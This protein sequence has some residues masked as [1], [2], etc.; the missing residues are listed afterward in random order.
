MTN[1]A[2]NHL[3]FFRISVTYEM[4]T[5]KQ[6]EICISNDNQTIGEE[7]FYMKRKG[8]KESKQTE[9]QWE[10]EHVCVCVLVGAEDSIGRH[11]QTA[12]DRETHLVIIDGRHLWSISEDILGMIRN[13]VSHSWPDI[14][15]RYLDR[16][17]FQKEGLSDNLTYFTFDL[18]TFD[19]FNIWPITHLTYVTF[20]LFYIWLINIWPI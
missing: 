18:L 5:T 10:S 2:L 4:R 15:L 12:W 13:D 20:D 7:G 19:L 3:T 6:G 11:P 8:G 1:L 16:R 9:R 14:W 17:Q